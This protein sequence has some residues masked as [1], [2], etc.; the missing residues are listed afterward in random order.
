[1]YVGVD[2]SKVLVTTGAVGIRNTEIIDLDDASFQCEV[3]QF[4]VGAHKATGGFVDNTALICGGHFYGD[5]K[6]CYSLKEDGEWKFESSL[7]TARSLTATGSVNMNHKLVIAG[8]IQRG[9]ENNLATIEVVASNTESVTLPIKLPVAMHSA[10]IVPW[11]TNT[12]MV[13]GGHD[14]SQRKQTLFIHM[15]NN[16][17]TEGPNLLVA[18]HWHACH[19]IHVNSEDYIIVAGGEG[20]SS[21]STEVLRKAN[22][23]TGWKKSKN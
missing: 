11:D 16:S 17:Y 18:R 12:F 6:S 5:Q 15:G 3:S 10:C 14:G 23:G 7:N 8:G 9:T 19:T 1:M 21:K 2:G 4:P 22:Y 13:I 20:A